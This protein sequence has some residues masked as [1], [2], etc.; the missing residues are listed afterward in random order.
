LVNFESMITYGM[1]YWMS[2]LL[3]A[4]AFFL[5]LLTIIHERKKKR[6]ASFCHWLYRIL[7]MIGAVMMA[8]PDS[9]KI[10]VVGFFTVFASIPFSLLAYLLDDINGKG[11][12]HE[13]VQRV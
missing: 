3:V 8:L 5:P 12:K 13:S 9:P 11:G 6:K 10:G 7:S 2:V 1:V 4:S